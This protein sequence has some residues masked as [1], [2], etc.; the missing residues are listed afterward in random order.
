MWRKRN[1]RLVTQ[2]Y[3]Q[4]YSDVWEVIIRFRIKGVNRIEENAL[5]ELRFHASCPSYRKQ[6]PHP[7]VGGDNGGQP[8]ELIL[9]G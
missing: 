2:A 5:P 3:A 7:S 8:L 4:R 6:C 1:D 9:G